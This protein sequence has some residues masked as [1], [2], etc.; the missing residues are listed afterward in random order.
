MQVYCY[1]IPGFFLSRATLPPH[2]I[3]LSCLNPNVPKLYGPG[4]YNLY[5][6]M[7]V[8]AV[9]RKIVKL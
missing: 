5:I 7:F 6:E 8:Y 4:H 9:G 1:F 3:P 2:V